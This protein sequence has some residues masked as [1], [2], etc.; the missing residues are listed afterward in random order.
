MSERNVVVTAPGRVEIVESET[1]PVPPGGFRAQTLYTGI[2]AG[3]ELSYVK[4]TN[5]ALHAAY[6]P[7]LGLFEFDLWLERA[8]LPPEFGPVVVGSS[9]IG[10]VFPFTLPAPDFRLASKRS[11]ALRAFMALPTAATTKHNPPTPRMS[12][13]ITRP[14]W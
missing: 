4:G 14:L 2:S 12:G 1:P 10:Y 3:T 6:D 8:P 7:V 9:A 13:R 5:P 11:H